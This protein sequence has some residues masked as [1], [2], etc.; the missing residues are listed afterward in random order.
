MIDSYIRIWGRFF[1][2]VFFHTVYIVLIF[3]QNLLRHL[4]IFSHFGDIFP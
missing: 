2:S 3:H 1:Y 4:Y